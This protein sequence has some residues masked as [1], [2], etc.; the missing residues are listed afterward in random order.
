MHL[1]PVTTTAPAIATHC[2]GGAPIPVDSNP[3]RSAAPRTTKAPVPMFPP[4]KCWHQVRSISPS[5]WSP[6][7][8][9]GD[10]LL[11]AVQVG[12]R[13]RLAMCP[14]RP[15]RR[16][17]AHRQLERTQQWTGS[18]EPADRQVRANG[19]RRGGATVSRKTSPTRREGVKHRPGEGRAPQGNRWWAEAWHRAVVGAVGEGP[20]V[21]RARQGWLQ[22]GPSRRGRRHLRVASHQSRA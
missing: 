5:K 8:S 20:G 1:C 17:M 15:P 12:Q 13:Q 10:D 22:G 18:E 4:Q 9:G 16:I 19:G 7:A 21:G 14:L 6:Y 11:Q 3:L 2:H